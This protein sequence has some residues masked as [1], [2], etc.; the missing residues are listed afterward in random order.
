VTL[1]VSA[2]GV[3]SKSLPVEPELCRPL[4]FTWKVK[5]ARAAPEAFVGGV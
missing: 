2:L 5:L 4:S 1:N 3:P